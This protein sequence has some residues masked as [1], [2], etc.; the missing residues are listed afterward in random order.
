MHFSKDWR[1]LFRPQSMRSSTLESQPLNFTKAQRDGVDVRRGVYTDVKTNLDAL[2]KAVQALISTQASYN[3]NLIAKATITPGTAGTTVL[4][5][6][7]T[8]TAVAADYDFSEIQLARAQSQVAS[9]PAGTTLDKP[10]GISGTYWL[11]GSG[12]PAVVDG[13]LASSSVTAAV[14]ASVTSGH[15]ELGEGAYSVE[16]RD[17]GGTRQ[18]RLVNADGDPVSI[19]K[20]DGSGT[21]TDWQSMTS[22]AFDTGRGFAL[23]LDTAGAPGSTALSYHAKGVSISIDPNDTLRILSGKINATIQPEG[24]DFKASLVG[25]QLVLTGARSGENHALLYSDA[26][27]TALNLGDIAGQT[28]RNAALK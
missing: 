2:Q 6:T 16:V 28:A 12:N 21:S 14:A 5:A 26:L 19:R 18:F 9:L 4:T 25:G 7:T 8:D 13:F 10:L 15:R 27:K 17:L 20:T 1:P 24:H 23:T 3:L 11:G 22:G